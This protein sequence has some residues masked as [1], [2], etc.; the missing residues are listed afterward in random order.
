MY[1][2]DETLKDHANESISRSEK[3]LAKTDSIE[4]QL[5]DELNPTPQEWPV[6][7]QQD[8]ILTNDSLIFAK[9]MAER[10]SVTSQSVISNVEIQQLSSRSEKP[11]E[12]MTDSCKISLTEPTVLSAVKNILLTWNQSQDHEDQTLSSNSLLSETPPEKSSLMWSEDKNVKQLPFGESSKK[13]A[14][15]DHEE[16][17]MPTTPTPSAA[18]DMTLSRYH[19]LSIQPNRNLSYNPLLYKNRCETSSF[20]KADVKGGNVTESSGSFRKSS[21]SIIIGSHE[22]V[23]LSD[24]TTVTK[25]LDIYL[26]QS[27]V[28]F[29][30]AQ[31]QQSPRFST[32]VSTSAAESTDKPKSC[33]ENPDFSISTTYIEKLSLPKSTDVP[34]LT[35]SNNPQLAKAEL[36]E[37]TRHEDS[38]EAQQDEELLSD[39]LP[40]E[41]TSERVTKAVV[42]GVDIKQKS[43]SSRKPSERITDI[44]QMTFPD[45]IVHT[46]DKDTL[47]TK[48]QSQGLEVQQDL[49]SDSLDFKTVKKSSNGRGADAKKQLPLSHRSSKRIA[50]GTCEDV[51]LS[52]ITGPIHDADMLSAQGQT[53]IVV[54]PK[55][56][57]SMS[58]HVLI[59][60][61][62]GD[63]AQS[64]M[65]GSREEVP[66]SSHSAK[67][68]P[69]FSAE[70][71]T[72][73]PVLD[74]TAINICTT[75]KKLVPLPT[76]PDALV[77]RENANSQMTEAQIETGNMD[78]TKILSK[79]S[80]LKPYTPERSGEYPLEE[81]HDQNLPS[82]V[83]LFFEF[84]PERSSLSSVELKPQSLF[85][86]NPSLGIAHSPENTL[87]DSH[88][89]VTNILL[90]RDQPQGWEAQ[91]DKKPSGDLFIFQTPLEKSMIWPTSVISGVDLPL[92]LTHED[93][94]LSNL[95]GLTHVP[96]VPSAREHLLIEGEQDENKHHDCLISPVNVGQVVE[97]STALGKSSKNI[98]SSHG[99]FSLSEPSVINKNRGVYLSRNRNREQT[100]TLGLSFSTSSL[101]RESLLARTADVPTPR[102]ST[103][104]SPVE[105]AQIYEE[106][107]GTFK[108]SLKQ[109]SLESAGV[110]NES[111][112][113][114]K[115]PRLQTQLFDYHKH[116]GYDY[117][118]TNEQDQQLPSDATVLELKDKISSV[119]EGVDVQQKLALSGKPSEKNEGSTISQNQKENMKLA[120]LY[121]DAQI[122]YPYPSVSLYACTSLDYPEVSDTSLKP[123]QSIHTVY[124]TEESPTTLLTL[125]SA[126]GEETA[127]EESSASQR[128][129]QKLN[130]LNVKTNEVA[131]FVCCI[132]PQTLS[133]A[134]WY[135]NDKRLGTTERIKFEQSGNI[136]S[137]LIYDLQPE[138]KGIYSCVLINKDGKTQTTS[139]QLNIEGGYLP[140]NHL[141]PNHHLRNIHIIP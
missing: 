79:T 73:K 13:A 91:E 53:Q 124:C 11:H 61:V 112:E 92:T 95:T 43:I 72:I 134:V 14:T 54:K 34:V 111:S 12:R 20:S 117:P 98:S 38:L 6:D 138:D 4:T 23:P 33:F 40:F 130:K 31:T 119:V 27:Q 32:K 67:T 71:I 39:T 16:F 136:L 30:Q 77:Q 86:D 105:E 115:K 125:P 69:T 101:S 60:D 126:E 25:A 19:H 102:E 52:Y 1:C 122:K 75:S 133:N 51:S 81:Q 116:I 68:S 70:S 9:T 96:G 45:P 93:I 88:P 10:S 121:Q 7:I 131:K 44:L 85:S 139:A 63:K 110:V 90:A 114:T 37:H 113:L 5:F 57:Q 135:H 128:V 29:D 97:P 26:N 129:I 50:F 17:A 62:K 141:I 49:A 82:N 87:P 109:I 8:E 106:D 24:P 46:K 3:A 76:S 89:N 78:S 137:L 80:I 83:D 15:K 140:C 35:G 66:L 120:I 104:S 84:T 123:F 103:I 65:I 28:A 18:R 2:S 56:D 74:K 58:P 42:K 127:F 132:D 47:L 107:V 64:L 108:S 118:Q 36:K 100:Q 48:D 22:E 55:Q 59:A 94:T 99:E 41:V 21:K